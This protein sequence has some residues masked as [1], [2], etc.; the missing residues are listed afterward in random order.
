M[1]R[2]RVSEEHKK[3]LKNAYDYNYYRA[4]KRKR[5]FYN[6]AYYKDRKL[7]LKLK[8]VLGGSGE[9]HISAAR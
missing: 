4:N 3:V 1:A 7:E 8:R 6:A 5:G 2:P 9:V